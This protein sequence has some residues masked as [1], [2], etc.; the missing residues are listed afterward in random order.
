MARSEAE[1]ATGHLNLLVT[2]VATALRNQNTKFHFL[3]L[4]LQSQLA[5]QLVP[6][7]PVP[8]RAERFSDAVARAVK[9]VDQ[10]G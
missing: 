1:L 9:Y 2:I 8:A 7:S 4:T 3:R 5:G 6:T 10:C